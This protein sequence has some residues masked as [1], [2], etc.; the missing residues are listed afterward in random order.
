MF[1]NVKGGQHQPQK[2]HL[3]GEYVIIDPCYIWGSLHH[4]SKAWDE[5]HK[6]WEW[7]KY[8]NNCGHDW[9]TCEKD[10]KTILMFGT[11]YGD[12]SYPVYQSGIMIG[13]FGVDS[14]KVAV[15]PKEL[16]PK[17]NNHTGVEVTLDGTLD[18]LVGIS[19]GNAIIG[20]VQIVTDHSDDEDEDDFDEEDEEIEEED[21]END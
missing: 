18:G 14:G 6:M 1:T 11:A 7:D 21:T 3:K 10:G 17:N 4:S 20:D 19:A 12:G 8:P 13:E 9:V 15:I 2:L 5:I 16:I